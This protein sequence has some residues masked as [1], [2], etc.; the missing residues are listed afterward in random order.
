MRLYS[1][2]A[3]KSANLTPII[4]KIIASVPVK[5]KMKPISVNIPLCFIDLY[6]LIYTNKLKVHCSKNDRKCQEDG[7]SCLLI[8]CFSNMGI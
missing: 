5:N 8:V 6:F 2:N 3:E 4:L 1:S 7:I